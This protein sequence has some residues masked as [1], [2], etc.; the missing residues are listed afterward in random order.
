M[1][2]HM[3]HAWQTQ[4]NAATHDIIPA[5]SLAPVIHDIPGATHTAQPSHMAAEPQQCLGRK[6]P[7]VSTGAL[8]LS[9]ALKAQWQAWLLCAVMLLLWQETAL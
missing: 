4:L 8:P 1:L 9:V 7:G 3:L 6:H 5:A 2:C